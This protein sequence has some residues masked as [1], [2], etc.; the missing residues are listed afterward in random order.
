VR[1]CPLFTIRFRAI[2]FAA[3]LVPALASAQAPT[4]LSQWGTSGSGP[5]Q[6]TVPY[7]VAVGGGNVYVADYF[8]QRIQ[9]FTGDGI[10]LAEW[11]SYGDGYGQFFNPAGVATDA[12]GNV[13]V[14][15]QGNYRIQKFTGD[16]VYLTQ[17]GSFGSED[18]QFDVP[19][20]VA[21]DADGNVYVTDGGANQRV[22]KFTGSGTY[23]TQWG[24]P[25]GGDGEFY[26]PTGV[27]TD[28]AGNVYV[29]DMNHRVQ[30]FTSTGMYLTQWGSL[31][32]EDG[33]FNQPSGLATD[34]NDN[35]YVVDLGN[36]RVQK[37]SGTG[38]YLAQ[39]GSFGSDNGQFVEWQ[40]VTLETSTSW[41]GATT[42]FRSSAWA[43]FPQPLRA[44]DGSRRCIGR[45][46]P[47]SPHPGGW[48]PRASA[49]GG[50]ARQQVAGPARKIVADLDCLPAGSAMQ[51]A[52]DQVCALLGQFE[53]EQPSRQ[54]MEQ[55]LLHD[56][57]RGVQAARA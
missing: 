46:P 10:Y 23:L 41:T 35:V 22:Q 45:P 7:G 56:F 16:G 54:E 13:Y 49:N 8:N 36:S 30:K 5:G 4:Y 48:C 53:R 33:Q 29:S 20:R 14:V 31:G 57:A 52:G 19:C 43:R 15:D 44:G 6:F 17:W 47:H 55:C 39:W 12:A 34:A 18:G 28:G 3:A 42:A 9:S 1:K 40:R 21:T 27:A 24:V 50:C 11:G 51:P 26:E 37:F 25:G 32:N 38:A 2:F